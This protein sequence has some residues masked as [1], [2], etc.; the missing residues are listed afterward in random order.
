MTTRC[1]RFERDF[2]RALNSVVEP[3]VR[4]GLLST[5]LTPASLIVLESVGF[6][7]GATRRTPLLS[8]GLGRFRLVSTVRGDRSFWVRNLQQ[9][10]RVRFFLG[11]RAREAEALVIAPDAMP[12]LAPGMPRWLRRFVARLQPLTARGWAFAI[13]Q[14]SA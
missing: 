8:L 1:Q 11:G 5:R 10:P 3:T 6:K 14:P 12:E 9:Q 4:R 7:S 13:L 2:F